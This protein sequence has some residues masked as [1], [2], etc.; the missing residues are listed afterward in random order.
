[1]GIGEKGLKKAKRQFRER[2]GGGKKV[3]KMEVL[4]KRRLQGLFLI[5]KPLPAMTQDLQLT[6]SLYVLSSCQPLPLT[7]KTI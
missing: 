7:S 5:T 2:M 1:M 6:C 4:G 3:D